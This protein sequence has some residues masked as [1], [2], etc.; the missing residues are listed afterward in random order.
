MSMPSW[1]VI[2]QEQLP[3]EEVPEVRFAKEGTQAFGEPRGAVR[4][5]LCPLA[6][7]CPSLFSPRGL[8]CCCPGNLPSENKGWGGQAGRGRLMD[9]PVSGPV[10]GV[11]REGL[12]HPTLSTAHPAGPGHVTA[13]GAGRVFPISPVAGRVSS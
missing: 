8:C 3:W 10:P 4:P 11:S 12:V 1:A 13:L 2:S 6:C 9:A 7:S 5:C